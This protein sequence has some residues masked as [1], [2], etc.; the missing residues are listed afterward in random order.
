MGNM[1]DFVVDYTNLNG[2]LPSEIGRLANL[3]VFRVN[4]N[5]ISGTIPTGVYS[6]S[7]IKILTL[8]DNEISGTL[9]SEGLW[10]PTLE[11]FG[12]GRNLEGT[13]PTKNRLGTKLERTHGSFKLT[14]RNRPN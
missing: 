4:T 13:I 1:F 11:M 7:N 2:T 12:T 10:T 9:P 3:G 6:L 14:N 8:F 5:L